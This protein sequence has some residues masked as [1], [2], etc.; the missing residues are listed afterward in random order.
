MDR[1]V[2]E[3]F[4]NL[5]VLIVNDENYVKTGKITEIFDNSIAFLT[6]GETIYLSFE[7]IKE[8]RPQERY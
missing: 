5:Y 3:R 8:I 7:R 2:I 4:L 1:E 6:K